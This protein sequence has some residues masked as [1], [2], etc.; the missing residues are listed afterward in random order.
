MQKAKHIEFSKEDEF[1]LTYKSYEE[2]VE[3]FRQQNSLPMDVIQEAIE[4]TNRMADSV[5][6]YDL[7][8]AFKYP[9]LYENEEE[10]FMNRIYRMY[11]EKLDK[12]I[13][14]P[15]SRYED[16]IKE[17]LRVFKKIGMIGFM[18]FMSE[19]ACWCWEH[20]IPIGFCRGSVGGSTIAFLT[21]ITDVDPVLWDTVFSRFA[22]EDRKLAI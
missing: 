1:D 2:L 6:D 10:V 3:M 13:I 14:K 4:N 12:G 18:L 9:I 5:T 19:L 22:N 21:D 20:D 7:D 16:N 8:T 11:H 17:E 15:D